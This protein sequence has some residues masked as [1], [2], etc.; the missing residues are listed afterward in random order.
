MRVSRILAGSARRSP[1]LDALSALVKGYHFLLEE[2]GVEAYRRM[3]WELWI[4]GLGPAFLTK[5]LYFAG[6]EPIR[7]SSVG[8]VSPLILDAV[9]TRALLTS[10]EVVYEGPAA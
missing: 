4:P 1:G 2:G 8:G 7:A 9:V 10:P 6:Y 3:S 5:F